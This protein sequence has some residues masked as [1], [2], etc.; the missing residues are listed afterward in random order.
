MNKLN[1]ESGEPIGVNVCV[2]RAD[3]KCTFGYDLIVHV[4]DSFGNRICSCDSRLMNRLTSANAISSYKM[5]IRS[6]W[7]K[8]GDYFI[9]ISLVRERIIDK[10]E[11]ACSFTVLNL[12]PYPAGVHPDA[13]GDALVFAD[14]SIA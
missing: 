6:P 3:D 12:L 9:T 13:I 1:Y 14:F 8:P 4:Y 10:L 7:L 2:E 5:I 11:M